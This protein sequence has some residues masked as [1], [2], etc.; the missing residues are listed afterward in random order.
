MSDLRT[1]YLGLELA[2]PIMPGASPL[3][4]DLDTVRVLEDAGAS[5]ITLRSLFEEQIEEGALA[6]APHLDAHDHRHAEAG[7][8]FPSNATLSLG[9]DAYL[10]QIAKIRAAVKVPVIASLNGVSLGGWLDY[11]GLMEQAGA[12]ALELNLYRLPTDPDDDAHVLEARDVAIVRA[13]VQKVKIPVAVKLSP[14]YTS[15][16]NHARVLEEA[17]A[18][19]LV[20][21]NR[22]YQPDI[23]PE[24]LEAKR[25]LHLSDVTELPLRLRWLAV[26]SAQRGVSLAASG[27][28]HDATGAVKAIMAGAHA[29]QI[30]SSLLVFGP[31]YIEGVIRKLGEWLEAHEYE[32]VDQLRGSLGR[33]SART[34]RKFSTCGNQN[35]RVFHASDARNAS[36][37][38]SCLSGA[39]WPPT[40]PKTASIAG[41]AFPSAPTKR[42][43]RGTRFTSSIPS[44]APSAWV[45]TKRKRA[46]LFARSNAVCPI[47]I[48]SRKRRILRPE[49]SPFTPRMRSSN[50]ALRLGTFHPASGAE[51]HDFC[52]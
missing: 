38:V 15:L 37:P 1:R 48:T 28:V 6:A 34:T 5:A 51:L 3:A 8:Y 18:R 24:A 39:A 32:S 13:V 36:W 30:V 52:A 20:C 45:S 47:R 31:R 17:G 50:N 40:S 26:L 49:R 12:S 46:R 35:K 29:V 42:S 16:P 2:H 10:E 21:F 41:H 43:P 44:T 25:E 23:D 33:T 19:G 14:F 9:P 22:F 11:A 27:G 7:S 4:D